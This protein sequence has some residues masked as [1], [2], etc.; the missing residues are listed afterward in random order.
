M[1]GN[2]LSRS[3]AR[4]SITSTK[5]MRPPTAP[6][7]LLDGDERRERMCDFGE[8]EI[9]ARRR[10][11]ENPERD[12]CEHR[13]CEEQAPGVKSLRTRFSGRP[14]EQWRR[15]RRRRNRRA[16]DVRPHVDER[17]AT[18]EPISAGAPRRGAGRGE[19]LLG[20]FRSDTPSR[21]RSVSDAARRY[22]VL[23]DPFRAEL[24]RERLRP[25]DDAWPYRVST[26][27][28]CRSAPSP[29]LDVTVTMRPAGER[30]R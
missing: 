14:L 29:R 11:P 15:S 9:V 10:E 25:T 13:A 20:G 23:R 16:R 4:R 26:E 30:S 21:R 27:R 12:R 19:I 6:P 1:L 7:G 5:W 2:M 3:V 8:D 22:A 28:G 24:A 17:N 18:R